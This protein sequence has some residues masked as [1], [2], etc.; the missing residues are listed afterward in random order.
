MHREGVPEIVDG[1]LRVGAAMSNITPSRELADYGGRRLRP[2][3]GD[4][5]LLCH[6]LAL[7]DGDHEAILLTCDATFIDRSLVLRIRDECE[8]RAA[9]PGANVL[10]AATHTHSAP[11]T[12]VSFVAGALPDPL[13]LD[14]F[15]E[16]V[17]EAVVAAREN[18]QP[19][20]VVAGTAQAPGYE[21]NRRSIR[22]D[23]SVVVQ[24]WDANWPVE[25]PVDPTVGFLGFETPEGEPV[26]LVASYACHNNCCG[27]RTYH[28]DVFGRC[29]DALRAIFP[30]L[31][32]TLLM[33]GTCGNVI[34]GDPKALKQLSGDADAKRV[35]WRCA[36]LIAAAYRGAPRMRSANLSL[37]KRWL[38]VPDRPL[39]ESTFCYDGCR[40][41]SEAALHSARQRYDP[42]K[43]ALEMRGDATCPLEIA[44][45]A[46]GDV[47]IVTNPAELFVE[48]GLE[49]KRRSPF[50]TTLVAE[51]ANGYCGYVPTERAFEHG[52]YETHR[53]V[54]TSRLAKDAGSRIVQASLELLQELHGAGMRNISA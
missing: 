51:L 50:G 3:D 37:S 49:I 34:H 41:S 36:Q 15:V 29:G 21:L 44:G 30:S 20:V 6:A 25:G 38:E 8:S 14:F 43:K 48:F 32:A 5:D 35:G 47:A 26:A 40:G 17:T 46:M 7:S 22:P 12:A 18:A 42:E 9:L 54:Y 13:Y 11:A 23:G 31:R 2:G 45:L 53:T 16:R 27:G 19:A 10:V 4:S 33:A 24:H 52:G 1:E 28:R 39:S